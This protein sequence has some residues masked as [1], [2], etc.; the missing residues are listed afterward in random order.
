DPVLGL[1]HR[2]ALPVPRR[3]P[4][5]GGSRQQL[6]PQARG[7]GSAMSATET[8]TNG[9]RT[10]LEV[11]HVSKFFGN[12]LALKDVSVGVESSEVTCVLGDN[13]AGKSTFIK[14]L[15][16]VHKHDEG[17]LLVEGEETNFGSPREAKALGIATVFQDLATVP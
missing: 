14:I 1:E 3:D 4:A 12:V 17:E 16:G 8:T 5:R 7:G 2:L 10:L 9:H 13:G 6:H 15:S 11:R